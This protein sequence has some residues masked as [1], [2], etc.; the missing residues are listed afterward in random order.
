MGDVARSLPT[1]PG[2]VSLRGAAGDGVDWRQDAPPSAGQPDDSSRW[3]PAWSYRS[4]PCRP[5]VVG[6]VGCRVD[7]DPERDWDASRPVI[8]GGRA[9]G[10]ES[11]LECG[12]ASAG[13]DLVKEAQAAFD[14]GASAAV[15][16]ELWGGAVA[17]AKIDDA[18]TSGYEG[19]RWLTRSDDPVSAMTVLSDDPVPLTGALAL[20]ES[21]LACCSDVARGVLHAPTPLLAPLRG[22]NL[23]L[24]PTTP[25]GRRYTPAGHTVVS[26]CGYTGSAPGTAAAG[27]TTP[28][29]GVLWMYVT[30]PLVVRVSTGVAIGTDEEVAALLATTNDRVAVVQGLAMAAWGCCHAGVPVDVSEFGL[31]VA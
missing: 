21:Y 3:A 24:E 11:Q 23:L 27:P 6:P 22:A 19:N 9:F 14:R 26:D 30:G 5:I 31:D 29:D 8:F 16:A 20:A 4:A 7:D 18:G 15:A 28:D 13:E 2:P 17:R 25:T 1:A 10:F 12:W